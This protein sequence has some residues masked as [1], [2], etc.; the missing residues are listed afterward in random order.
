MTFKK[1]N[2]RTCLNRK[3]FYNQ[4]Q[5]I[6]EYFI[7]MILVI[8]IAFFAF[9]SSFFEGVKSDCENAFNQAVG[10]ILR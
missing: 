2:K 6:F 9:S 7:L 10:D 8:G 4:G 5:A 1:I 3:I